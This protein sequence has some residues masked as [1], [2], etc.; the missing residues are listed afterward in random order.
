MSPVPRAKIT[1]PQAWQHS[2]QPEF[3]AEF[4]DSLQ[5]LPHCIRLILDDVHEL[6]APEAL[7]VV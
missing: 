6:V 2:S 3:I 5:G 1:A 4:A 7:Y